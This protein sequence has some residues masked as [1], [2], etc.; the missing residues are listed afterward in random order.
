MS[1]PV[2]NE[3]S[4]RRLVLPLCLLATCLTL[5]ARAQD[6]LASRSP[7]QLL[8]DARQSVAA[9][10]Y[11]PS[12]ACYREYLQRRPDDD[13]VRNELART[14]SWNS[15]YDSAL[16][17]YAVVLARNKNNF[18]ARLGRCRVLS[19]KKEYDPALRESDEL[20]RRFPRNVELLNFAASLRLITHD[21]GTSLELYNRS[22]AME[23]EDLDAML[24]R[25]RAL[26]GLGRSEEAFNGIRNTRLRYP[27][28]TEVGQLYEL[29]KPKPKN[30]IFVRYQDEQFDVQGRS[31][32]RTLQA[33]YY[34]TMAANLT[35][36]VE[37]DALRRF[38]QN[39]ASFGAGAYYSL[40]DRQ[41]VFG[42]CLLSPDPKV[43]STV[44][45]SVEFEQVLHRSLSV[46]AAYRLLDFKSEQAHII[47]PGIQWSFAQA[48]ELRPRVF[49]SRTA[50]TRKTS[51]AFAVQFSYD[52]WE[53]LTPSIFYTVGNEAYRGET[54]DNV[55][56]SDSWSLTVTIKYMLA[57]WLA[58]RGNYQYLNRI[59]FFRENSVDLGLGTYW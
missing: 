11:A 59:G 53:K 51:S 17:V 7:D 50:Q 36:Y 23:A 27:S 26:V 28:N 10:L 47:A 6:S 56:S 44:D 32:H 1:W 40:S 43:T 34:R 22:L 35:V 45:A 9:K 31:D 21:F 46:F 12:I 25:C 52:G 3:C 39:D 49:I 19:W 14:Y 16:S 4:S 38:D 15:E 33:Q 8:M 58:I 41:T 57:D 42:Y 54:L 20:L 18:D 24:G 55:E 5:R 48:F 13:D 2:F 29:L 30:Q 37:G